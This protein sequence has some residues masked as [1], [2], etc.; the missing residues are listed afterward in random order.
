[1]KFKYHFTVTTILT[2]ILLYFYR[3]YIFVFCFWLGGIFIDIDHCFDYIRETGDA[4]IT[5][6]KMEKL[7]CLYQEKKTVIF[8]HSYEFFLI[9]FLINYFVI[10]IDFIYG[11]LAGFITHIFFD[12]LSN[13]VKIKAY[14]FL[15][16]LKHSFD[17]NKILNL[18]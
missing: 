5:L 18:N 8:L 11:L 12:I 10:K 7:F 13:P 14:F 3:N 15:Y 1:M 17:K 16:R 6:Q 4:K 9:L 2:C